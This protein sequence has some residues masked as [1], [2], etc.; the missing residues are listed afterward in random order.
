[1]MG[2]SGIK[3]TMINYVKPPR[4]RVIMLAPVSN[5]MILHLNRPCA[6][7]LSLEPFLILHLPFKRKLTVL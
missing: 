5:S 2:K 4:I 7:L 1:M 6:P 3:G